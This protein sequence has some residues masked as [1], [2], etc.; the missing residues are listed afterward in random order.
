MATFSWRRSHAGTH[1]GRDATGEPFWQML[2]LGLA[3][4]LFGIAVLVWPGQTLRLL[5]L[6]VAIWLIVLGAMR[7]F[8]AFD[9]DQTTATRVMSGVIAVVLFAAGIACARNAT[10]SVLVLATLVGLAWLLSGFAELMIGMLARGPA[11]TWL[12]VLGADQPGPLECCQPLDGQC[13]RSVVG[14]DRR[15]RCHRVAPPP[16]ADH[17]TRRGS[18]SPPMYVDGAGSRRHCSNVSSRS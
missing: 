5:G 15:S 9:R 1:P 14:R 7:A 8:V 18:A 4:V 10:G 3:T 16:I 6:L 17:A 11:R 2:S 12:S 13:G